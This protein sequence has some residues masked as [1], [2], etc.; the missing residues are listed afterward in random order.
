MYEGRGGEAVLCRA[1]PS[2]RT[3]GWRASTA[4]WRCSGG[5]N[6]N[7]LLFVPMFV[8]HL[9]CGGLQS[10]VRT[11]RRRSC[12]AGGVVLLSVAHERMGTSSGESAAGESGARRSPA[13]RPF[14][15]HGGPCWWQA[16]CWLTATPS[17]AHPCMHAAACSTGLFLSR[18]TA[19]EPNLDESLQQRS[20]FAAESL[21]RSLRLSQPPRTL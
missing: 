17:P 8:C 3:E 16:A 6:G 2:S 15:R 4:S 14:R 12:G 21:G 10:D 11:T 20:R 13:Q 1:S 9:G 18:T 19:V 7:K 5:Q